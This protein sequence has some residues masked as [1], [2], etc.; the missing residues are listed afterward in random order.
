MLLICRKALSLE[1]DK[2]KQCNLAVCLMYTNRMT[3]AKFLLNSVENSNRN[4]EMYQSCAKSYERAIKVLNEL[5]SCKHATSFS[6]FLSRNKETVSSEEEEGNNGN[7]ES[8]QTETPFAYKN[9]GIPTTPFTQPRMH[10]KAGLDG[11][12][13]RKLQFGQSA[14]NQDH[15]KSSEMTVTPLMTQAGTRRKSWADIAEEEEEEE[16]KYGNENVDWCN[17][18]HEKI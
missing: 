14:E 10:E 11:G 15:R 5:E 18:M 7:C 1:Q 12:C 8:M 17:T 4:R 3:E 16:E 9:Q 2:N 13:F 6:S